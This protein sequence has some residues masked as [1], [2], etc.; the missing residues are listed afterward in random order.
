MKAIA[1]ALLLG[2]CLWP[3]ACTAAPDGLGRLFYTATE[4]AEMEARRHGRPAPQEVAV[5]ELASMLRI[6]GIAVRP[7]G[8][9]TIW[10]NGAPY[11]EQDLPY[12]IRVRRGPA[13]RILG[14]EMPLEGG[15]IE[16]AAI[17]ETLLRPLSSAAAAASAPA[18]AMKPEAVK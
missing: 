14:V 2:C 7:Q 12:G 11:L 10:I 9:T 16:R 6:D 8:K 5:R 1:K 15:D 3:L 13:G 4:R 18:T 17:G